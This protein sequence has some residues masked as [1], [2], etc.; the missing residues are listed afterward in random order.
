M[1]KINRTTFSQFRN[2]A[3]KFFDAVDR[4]EV[5]EI[6]RHGK[7]SAVLRPPAEDHST[8]RKLSPFKPLVLDGVSVSKMILKERSD[9]E[10]S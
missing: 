6:Y 9:A 10:E 2:Q 5:I 8:N 1:G 4:G 3:K 7:L